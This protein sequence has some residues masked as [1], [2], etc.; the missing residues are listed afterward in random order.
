MIARISKHINFILLI[1]LSTIVTFSI[2]LIFL[3][4]RSKDQPYKP[5]DS[6]I[7]A[8]IDFAYGLRLND[9]IIYQISDENL[10]PKIDEW[11]V[12]HTIQECEGYPEEP[13][14]GGGD[15]TSRGSFYSDIWECTI[16][17]DARYIF[18]VYDIESEEQD[19]KFVI[20]DWGEVEEKIEP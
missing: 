8:S 19:G 16:E 11:M 14:A 15:Q 17:N 6:H 2:Y 10:W 7:E 9:P 3:S 1:V 13:F 4:N 20:V 18:N 5:P 12:T